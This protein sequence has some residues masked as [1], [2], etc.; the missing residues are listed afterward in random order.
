MPMTNR[1]I[2]EIIRNIRNAKIR[3]AEVEKDESFDKKTRA[4]ASCGKEIF[5]ELVS[6][7]CTYT[8]TVFL[9]KSKNSDLNSF[10]ENCNSIEEYKD[11]FETLEKNRKSAHNALITSVKMADFL[12]EKVGAEKI[13]GKIPEKYQNDISEVLDP[14]CRDVPGVV[15][16]RHDIATWTWE[17]VIGSV[18]DM[19]IDITPNSA[20]NEDYKTDR[21]TIENLQEK[22]NSREA[23]RLIERLTD[24]GE[25]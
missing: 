17:F 19:N 20:R 21:E 2:D 16:I 24:V 1:E 11:K 25:R 18:I 8:D 12:C 5:D 4:M 10:R 15:E 14:D 23:K 9:D 13:Y 7:M 3:C 6:D 22:F